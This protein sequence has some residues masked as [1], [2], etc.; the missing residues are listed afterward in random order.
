MAP[1]SDHAFI[2]ES[3]NAKSEAP[4]QQAGS[5]TKVFLHHISREYRGLPQTNE[6]LL[7]E[8]DEGVLVA[9]NMEEREPWRVSMAKH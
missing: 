1:R 6:R 5:R 4:P 2:T 9:L 8:V 3:R 7:K